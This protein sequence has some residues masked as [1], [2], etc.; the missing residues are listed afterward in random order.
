M[1]ETK[2]IWLNGK[3]VKWENA[4]I[5]LLAH[6]LHYGSGCFEGIRCYKTSKGAAIFRLKDHVERILKSFSVFNIICPY[7]N[8]EI[9]KA[10]IQTIKENRIEEC[11]IRPIIF[12]GYGEMG[13]KNLDKCKI[14]FA[15][16]V[17]SWP[18][19]L[20]EKIISA[21]ITDIIRLHPRSINV[22]AK[23]CGYYI[24][25]ILA[26]LEAKKEGYD[27]A[28]LLDYK[29]KIAEGPGENIFL[30]KNEKIFTPKKGN[31]LPGITRDSIIKIAKD[32]N[33]DV[34]EKEIGINELLSADEAFFTGTACEVAAIGKIN[35]K[36]ISKNVGK[37]T[38]KIKEAY[39]DVVRGKNKKYEKWLTYIKS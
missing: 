29:G 21:K 2:Y 20:G 34:I 7:S 13:L 17:W 1:E 6:G 35:D 9:E 11:Y 26:T 14:N 38:K 30:V 4:K 16:A 23:L 15:V 24:N 8:K 19:Y 3:L 18:A 33:Y 25:S 37:I 31:I 27:E 5:H 12:F 32:L 39:I 22:E 36:I 10:I 28:I